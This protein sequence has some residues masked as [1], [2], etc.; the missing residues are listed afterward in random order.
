MQLT[1][2]RDNVYLHHYDDMAQAAIDFKTYLMT[3]SFC[4]W[5]GNESQEYDY[6]EYDSEIARNNGSLWITELSDI[7]A[8]W[9]RNTEQFLL[10]YNNY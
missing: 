10:A 9:G 2:R 6:P 5:D 8:D 3:G 4:D 7:P 1:D